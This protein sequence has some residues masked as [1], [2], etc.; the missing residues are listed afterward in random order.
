M[1]RPFGTAPE[2]E[3]RRRQAVATRRPRAANRRRQ[4]ETGFVEKNEMR[5]AVSCSGHNAR[6]RVLFPEINRCLITLASTPMRLLRGPSQALVKQPPDVIVME[7]NAEVSANQFGNTSARPQVVAPAVGLGPLAKEF[8]QLV[9]LVGRQARRRAK[10]RLGSQTVKLAGRSQP[11][12]NGNPCDAQDARHRFG[13]FPAVNS[14]HRLRASTFEFR[15]SSEGST[16]A[17]LDAQVA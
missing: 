13:A 4:H 7:R 5:A 3:R 17:T 9:M 8:F 6:E 1:S 11:T 16:H 10:M 15:G 2:L 12:I 14:S